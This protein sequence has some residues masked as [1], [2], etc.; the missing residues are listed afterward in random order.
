M[1]HSDIE[2]L[3]SDEV[4]EAIERN[5]ER[6]AASIALDR[7]VP[8]ASL[9]ATQV[10]YLQRARRKLPHLYEVRAIIPPR[11]FEQSSSEES[12]RRKPLSGHSVLDLTC[13]LGI[14]TMALAESFER[15]VSI[16]RDPQLADV[17]RNNLRMLHIDNVEV[18]TASA[19]E[20]VATCDDHFD[21]VFADPDR[22]SEDGRKMVVLEECSPNMRALMPRLSEIASRVAIKLS[23]M[24]DSDEALRIFAPAEV[25]IVSMGGECKEVNIY[26]GAERDTLRIAI[27]GEG[28]WCFDPHAADNTPSNESFADGEWR[29]MLIPDVALQKS[30]MAMTALKPYAAIW[31]NNGY[32]FTRE[33]PP[34]SLPCRC[35][36]IRSIRRYRP[37]ELKRE[38]RGRGID[39]LKHDTRL[40]VEGVRQ[41]L[42]AKAGSETRVAITTIEQDNWFIELV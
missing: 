42:G 33:L 7:S 6:D 23:P 2:I 3:L 14:D 29:Y 27:I 32:A 18:V 13:G 5:I 12:A 28:E 1:T 34:A 19:E 20:Y 17:V 9:V 16:E 22:R 39:I 15:V 25:E 10:K 11:A 21:W 30:R 31:S 40:T 35:F 26:T 8:Y 41:A 36:A 37:K 4:R 38:Y 24:F